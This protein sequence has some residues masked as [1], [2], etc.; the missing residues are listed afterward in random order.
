MTDKKSRPVI[1]FGKPVKLEKP[2]K[3]AVKFESL[4]QAL[5][6]DR[7]FGRGKYKPGG[8]P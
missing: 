3:P 7:T 1:K 6:W 4:A 5:V 2:G 8:K